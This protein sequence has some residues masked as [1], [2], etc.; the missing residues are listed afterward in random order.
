[1][2]RFENQLAFVTGGSEGIGLE[3]ARE[4]IKNKCHV[5]IFSRSQDKLSKALGS[6]ELSQQDAKQKIQSVPLDLSD[7]KSSLQ[8]LGKALADFGTPDLLINCAG[9]AR[10]GYL[11]DL[12]MEHIQ[13][14]MNVNY[15]GIVNACKA[16]LPSMLDRKKGI[17]INTSSMAG[18]IG[19]FGYTGYCASKYAV[20]GFSEALMREVQPFGITVSVLCPPNTRTPGLQ[21]ENKYKPAEVLKAEEKAKTVDPDFIAK[22]LIKKLPNPPFMI[23]PTFDGKL[24]HKLSRFAPAILSTFL[25]RPV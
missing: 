3:V 2:G 23:V 19:V 11:V 8:A 18:F 1:M 20:V 15:F 16:I 25:R 6:L 9:Y 4:L 7:S 24:A 12:P 13:G 22:V 17:I 5:V 10:P 14:M 21:E